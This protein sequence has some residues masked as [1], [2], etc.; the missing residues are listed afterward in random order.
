MWK[1]P[2]KHWARLRARTWHSKK[3]RILRC[4][5]WNAHIKSRKNSRARAFRSWLRMANAQTGCAPSPNSWFTAVRSSLSMT[6]RAERK[7]LDV[8]LVERGLAESRQ[9]A[10]AMILAGEV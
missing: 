9:K 3:P 4:L 10:Q 8:L 2:L 7:R 6:R 1:S 5:A